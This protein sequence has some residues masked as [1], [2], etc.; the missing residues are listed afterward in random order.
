MAG[1]SKDVAFAGERSLFPGGE[2]F[3]IEL[4]EDP[5]IFELD[6]FRPIHRGLESDEDMDLKV[7]NLWNEEGL[8]WNEMLIKELFDDNSANAILRICPSLEVEKELAQWTLSSDQSFS[9]KSMYLEII[10][11]RIPPMEIL[12]CTDWNRFWSL[13]IPDRI[14]YFLWRV[15]WN[16]LPTRNHLA[17]IIPNDVAEF[18]FC[19]L[20]EGAL[21]TV[22]HVFLYCP[23]VQCVWRQAPWPLN[24]ELLHLSSI[25]DWIQVVLNPRKRLAI[26]SSDEHPVVV[27]IVVAMDMIWFLRNQKVHEGISADPSLLLNRIKRCYQQHLVAWRAKNYQ[28][29]RIWIAPTDG[30]FKINIDAAVKSSFV[31]LACLCYDHHGVAV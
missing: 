29:Q 2:K 16:A 31:T 17:R 23:I 6:N 28:E 27:Y 10:K 18:G 1:C 8:G 26:T 11:D 3:R 19:P 14:K 20:C 22:E 25:V 7:R 12:S 9:V 4:L 13:K 15:V 24:M 30:V 5:W 21:E